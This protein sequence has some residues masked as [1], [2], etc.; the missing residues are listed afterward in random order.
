MSLFCMVSTRDCLGPG[1]IQYVAVHNIPGAF[2]GNILCPQASLPWSPPPHDLLLSPDKV[3]AIRDKTLI[4]GYEIR[5]NNI[6]EISGLS[7][8]PLGL[9]IED[10]NSEE[11]NTADV[12]A[13]LSPADVTKLLLIAYDEEIHFAKFP[14]LSSEI[15]NLLQAKEHKLLNVVDLLACTADGRIVFLKL[16]N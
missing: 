11:E 1:T 2:S 13:K 5:G 15:S 4:R 6:S 14:R 3:G 9:F 16:N 7:A 12:V 10:D 8:I